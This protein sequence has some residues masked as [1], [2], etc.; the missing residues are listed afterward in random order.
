MKNLIHLFLIIFLVTACQPASPV[1]T[2]LETEVPD[3]LI[4]NADQLKNADIKTDSLKHQKVTR[5]IRVSGRVEAPPQNYIS[6]SAPLG[7]FLRST[8]LLPGMK[9]KKGSVLAW[10]EDQQYI[11]LQEQYLMTKAELGMSEMEFQRQA[12]LNTDKSGSDKSLEQAKAA[13]ESKKA[14]FAGL[15][16]KLRMV[17]LQ[18]DQLNENNLSRAV[19][20]MSPIDGYVV[21]INV[22]V[23]KYVQPQDALFELVNPD[24]IHL[25]LTIFEKDIE[26]LKEGQ[27]VK[28]WTNNSDRR[29]DCEVILLGRNIDSDRSTDVH[30]HFLNYDHSLLPGMFMNAEIAVNG[31]EGAVLPEEALVDFQGKT[32]VFVMNSAS[33]FKMLPVL[34]VDLGKGFCEIQNPDV[35][36]N[37]KIVVHGAYSLLMMLKNTS[38]D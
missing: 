33:E 31:H 36:E 24:D 4:L 9:V 6:V 32:Y 35:L 13:F 29:Y 14:L 23:G 20:L 38:E 3:V 7:G 8:E 15:R 18:P 2:E 21:K 12:Q 26:Y 30:C 5:T 28:A 10:M 1:E 19:P 34:K 16:E 22:N 27:M 17:G 37:K 25:A 11:Q